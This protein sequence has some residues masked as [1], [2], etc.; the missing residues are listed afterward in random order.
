MSLSIDAIARIAIVLELIPVLVF[1]GLRLRRDREL[2]EIAL[3]IPLAVSL[4]LVSL[5][6][7]TRALPLETSILVSRP[8]WILGGAA[9]AVRTKRRGLLVW[10]RA[11]GRMDVACALVSACIAVY[12]SQ[13]ISRHC[14]V[15]DRAWHS[16]VVPSIRAETIPFV[17]VYQ[18][19]LGLAYHYAG[20]VLGASIQVLSQNVLQASNALSWAHD[21]AFGLTG[22]SAALLFRWLGFRSI[23]GACLATLGVL[24]SGPL[25]IVR[26]DRPE[27]GYNFIDLFKLS[28]RPHTCLATLL[29]VGFV[30]AML[31]RL[32]P[33]GEAILVRKTAPILLACT[34]LLAVTDET[35][36]GLFGLAIGAAWLVDAN[37]LAPSRKAGALVL[38]ALLATLVAATLVFASALAPGAPKH[39][40]QFVPWRSPGYLNPPIPL[41]SARGL[42]ML[43]YDLA[44]MLGVLAA[45][46]LARLRTQ[47]RGVTP[48]LVFLFVVLGVGV[49]GLCRIDVD[50]APIEN[51]RFMTAALFAFPFI[52]ATWLPWLRRAPGQGWSATAGRF[53]APLFIVSVGLSAASTL[54]WMRSV[55]TQRWCTKPKNYGSRDDFFK[56]DCVKEAGARFGEKPVP[57]YVEQPVYFIQAGCRPGFTSGP[58][59]Q[60]W[61]LRIGYPHFGREALLDFDQNMLKPSEP[62]RVV[63]RKE[64]SRDPI[65]RAA[66]DN[67]TCKPQGSRLVQCELS[68][69]ERT[70]LLAKMTKRA[71]AHA[72]SK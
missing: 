9:Y 39:L 8:L 55:G 15:A 23:T 29:F 32:A 52:G 13:T 65:C 18:P 72:R 67:G 30:G 59:V 7:L 19:K 20:D 70:A 56:T 26:H 37:V 34:A 51:H 17:N 48:G 43:L 27:G 33:R 14:H 36:L 64:G 3:D 5:L 69:A 47:R 21:V 31:V 57:T 28:Y 63:C 41:S 49:F 10:P 4:D 46:V 50:D 68:G 58:P 54:W 12:L 42:D 35:S 53:V 25:T 22:A 62:L 16:G 11:L 40:I 44:P 2:W 61:A 24:L 60:Q 66:A 45:G 38:V 6:L 1:V 71:P